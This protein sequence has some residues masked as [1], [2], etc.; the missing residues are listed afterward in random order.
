MLEFQP[1]PF[2]LPPSH[3]VV[4]CCGTRNGVGTLDTDPLPAQPQ[5]APG[6]AYEDTEGNAL[7]PNNLT[8]RTPNIEEFP[9]VGPVPVTVQ[10]SAQGH[11][12]PKRHRPPAQPPYTAAEH[13]GQ[14]FSIPRLTATGCPPMLTSNPTPTSHRRI[15]HTPCI[16]SDPSGQSFSSPVTVQPIAQHSATIPLSSPELE[17]RLHPLSMPHMAINDGPPSSRHRPIL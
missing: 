7:V 5:T 1:P 6:R 14:S 11:L 17:T 2:H 13:S 10:P 9:A 12:T 15:L 16:S 8:T 3:T 4:Y